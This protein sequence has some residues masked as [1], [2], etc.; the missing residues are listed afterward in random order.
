MNESRKLKIKDIS[1]SSVGNIRHS[2]GDLKDLTASI[3]KS[4]ILQPLTVRQTE[5]P[6]PNGAT[7]ELVFGH[8]RYAAA[9]SAKFADVPVIVRELTD[10]QVIELQLVENIQQVGEDATRG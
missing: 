3:K 8:R 10:A 5:V 4:G 7:Y 1:P 9:V 6:G 2:L